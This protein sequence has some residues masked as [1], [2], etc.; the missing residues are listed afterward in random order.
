[1]K[2]SRKKQDHFLQFLMK[3]FVKNQW[4]PTIVLLYSTLA[5][6][7]WYYFSPEFAVQHVVTEKLVENHVITFFEGTSKVFSAFGVFGVLPII[8]VK[9]VFR[10]KLADYGLQKGNL[11]RLIRGTLICVPVAFILGF[12]TSY[13]PAYRAVYPYNPA[14]TNSPGIFLCHA[15][16]YLT[17]YFGWEFFF[18]GFLQN[19]LKD[20]LGIYNAILIQTMASAMLHFGHPCSEAIAS[21][22]GGILWGIIAVRC[23]SIWSGFVQH[24]VL[25]ITLDWF[26]LKN[27]DGY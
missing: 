9:F 7:F 11:L 22:F 12:W 6:I 21:I 4:K 13:S 27:S 24:S 8:I 14:V 26:L 1:M 17:Y 5:M 18:R 3:F 20:S 2:F 10:E 15:A 23:G 25:G 16:T 19:G